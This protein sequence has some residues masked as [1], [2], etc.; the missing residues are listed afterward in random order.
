MKKSV[1]RSTV[2]VAVPSVWAAMALLP[3][4]VDYGIGGQLKALN[5]FIRNCVNGGGRR[6]LYLRLNVTKPGARSLV[7]AYQAINWEDVS[8]AVT[9]LPIEAPP[10]PVRQQVAAD[11][12]AVNE[13][14]ANDLALPIEELDLSVGTYNP[15]KREGINTIGDLVCRTEERL[16]SIRHIAQ[17]RI[18]EIKFK[19]TGLGLALATGETVSATT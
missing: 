11:M 5:Q 18:D 17:R 19:L 7:R 4:T 14:L 6:P 8:D 15:L 2:R 9:L 1:R 12:T 13:Q 16:G 3:F 10:R